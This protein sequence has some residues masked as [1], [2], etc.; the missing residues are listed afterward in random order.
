[1]LAL[2][3]A[4]VRTR[5]REPDPRF[6]REVGGT[7]AEILGIVGDADDARGRGTLPLGREGSEVVELQER[8]LGDGDVA[9]DRSEAV[10]DSIELIRARID[11]GQPVEG[12]EPPI[13]GGLGGSQRSQQ[14]GSEDDGRNLHEDV[15]K[16]NP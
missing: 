1:M 13:A 5:L 2:V 10:V 3:R 12:L 8:D 11:R 9:D 14:Q 15:S 7:H 16:W 6:D 4:P